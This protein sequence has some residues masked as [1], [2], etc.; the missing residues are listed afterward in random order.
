MFENI[1][2]IYYG[3]IRKWRDIPI[4][5]TMSNVFLERNKFGLIFVLPLLNLLSVKQFSEIH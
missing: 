5:G 4:Y 3:Y 2:K 1:A